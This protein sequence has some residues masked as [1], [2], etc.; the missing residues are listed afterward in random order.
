MASR[1]RTTADVLHNL[2]VE[3][4]LNAGRYRSDSVQS[5]TSSIWD[6]MSTVKSFVTERVF[7]RRFYWFCALGV[8][9]II[10]LH[11]T[12]LPRSSWS[13]DFRRW[14]GLH[15]TRSDVRRSYLVVSGIGNMYK[16]NSNEEYLDAWLNNMTSL[17]GKHPTSINSNA[18]PELS[19]FVY[20]QFKKFG[21]QTEQFDFEMPNPKI[22]TSLWIEL[23]NSQDGKL[24]YKSPL[25]ERDY[26][27]PAFNSF[28][29]SGIINAPYVYVHHGHNEDYD[30]LKDAKI[31]VSGK[32]VIIKSLLSS[33]YTLS[34]LVLIAQ[35][36]GAKG[37]V[38]FYD[39]TSVN[40]PS[41]ESLLGGAIS[42][43]T[44][45]EGD[46]W[47]STQPSI[48]SLPVSLDAIQPILE[49][50]V[51][52][53]G[54]N[55]KFQDWDY[56]PLQL[57]ASFNLTLANSV[58]FESS[59]SKVGKGT[60]IVA[61]MKG[62]LND[63]QVV[64][65]S[66]RDSFASSNP[67]SGQVILFE[68]L[69]NFKRLQQMGWKPLRTI[70]FVSWDASCNNVLGS[71]ILSNGTAKGKSPSMFNTPTIGY[72]DIDGDAVTGSHFKVDSNPIFNHI[73]KS[74]SLYVPI[75]RN[76]LQ[77]KSLLELKTELDSE[78]DDDDGGESFTT[79]YHYWKLQDNHTINNFLGQGISKSDAFVIQNHVNVP[80][81]KVGFSNDPKRDLSTYIPNSNYF[82]Y[83]WIVQRQMDDNL[84]LHGS[85]VRYI[86]LVMLSLT[87]HYVVDY[88]TSSYLNH[89]MD[90]YD[91]VVNHT[92]KTLQS[93]GDQ[94][95][96]SYLISGS[97]IYSDLKSGT[98]P[99][100]ELK[101][102]TF[103]QLV[104][105]FEVLANHL[106]NQ[107]VIFDDYNKGVEDGLM[108]DYPWYKYFKKLQHFAQLK[109][110][111]T[112][113][114]HLENS[115]KLTD[116]EWQ[117][118]GIKKPFY[119]HLLYG[120]P[121]FDILKPQLYFDTRN[122][123]CGF[124]YIVDSIEEGDFELTVKW[125]VIVYKKLHYLDKK[126]A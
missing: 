9:A 57:K 125:L 102:V 53:G 112:K 107:L 25:L 31:D 17:N 80:V 43:N 101:V 64:I 68:I 95:V 69:R 8:M 20:S 18:N 91:I 94:E 36:R 23:I 89:A 27:T 45:L 70:K 97:D 65:G 73:L 10:T 15:L 105:Q 126:L 115:M 56:S 50:L 77:F 88:K 1:H 32:I 13:R 19:Q 51:N 100:T 123:M 55:S 52:Y 24:V 82:S 116:L 46:I 66:R 63:G 61:T 34:E 117:Y 124:P 118:I 79:L 54:K 40:N 87:E 99:D 81:I 38:N 104:E 26:K 67:L 62:I 86:G 7:S 71:Q 98:S 93:W 22:P 114:L 5:T 29:G 35:S 85:L 106:K 78:N 90:L 21:F 103:S 2:S 96:K 110:T 6:D 48:I 4:E 11:L 120:I 108:F 47:S 109:V 30:T 75:P 76:S 122:E 42:R 83:S 3:S 28:S 60:N 113:L 49:T 59:D 58:T 74:D 41:S 14:H 37:V 39:F 16:N 12:F 111:N 119:Y 72:V 84:L 92:S 33:N 121:K 44:L